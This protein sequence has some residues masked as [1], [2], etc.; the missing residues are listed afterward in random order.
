MTDRLT[1]DELLGVW[2]KVTGK[3]ITSISCTEEEF[4][5]FWPVAGEEYLKQLLW[6]VAVPDWGTGSETQVSKEELG[7]SGLRNCEETLKILAPT[8]Q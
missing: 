7:I 8:W 4:K 5:R 3:V 2:S 6:H 1:L